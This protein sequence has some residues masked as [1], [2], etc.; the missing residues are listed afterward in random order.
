MQCAYSSNLGEP[1]GDMLEGSK[2]LVL[3]KRTTNLSIMS[4]VRWWNNYYSE[5]HCEIETDEEHEASIDEMKNVSVQKK[6]VD[7][8]NVPKSDRVYWH[9]STVSSQCS[10]SWC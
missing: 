7:S 10:Q 6:Q 9:R 8:S 2:I 4:I 1:S 5:A 3:C